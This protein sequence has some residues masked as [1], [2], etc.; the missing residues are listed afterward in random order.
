MLG[1]VRKCLRNASFWRLALLFLTMPV[2]QAQQ[3]IHVPADRPTIQAGIDAAQNGDTVLVSPGTYNEN[4]DFRG[5]GIV[6]TSGAASYAEAAA[7]VINAAVNGPVVKLMASEPATAV[8]NGFTIQGGYGLENGTDI[9]A[10]VA[11]YGS[12]PAITN[13]VIQKNIGC[14]IVV[15]RGGSPI[16]QGND[17]RQNRTIEPTQL[18][19]APTCGGAMSQPNDGAGVAMVHAGSVTL[20]GNI[21]E[22]NSTLNSGGTTPGGSGDGGTIDG[23][24][25]YIAFTQKAF[26][27]NN[28][29]RNNAGVSQA[30]IDAPTG[31]P[32]GQ[33]ILIQNFFYV[34]Q[35][36]PPH[37]NAF[38]D[39]SSGTVPTQLIAINNTFSF[40]LE[41]DQN[42]TADSVI[43]NNIIGALNC[44]YVP[45]PP[46]ISHNDIYGPSLYPSFVCPLGPGNIS[47]DPQFLNPTQGNFHTQR[48]SPVV[49]AGDINAPQIPPTDLDGKNRTVCGTIDMGVY[50]VHPQPATVV[51]SSL[52]PSVGG[53]AV[54]FGA[55][56]PG[57]CN[58]PTGTVT[59]FDG[60][61]AL[62]S[63]PL[64]SGATAS[65]TTASLTVGTHT[66]TV[67]YSGDFNFDPSTSTP[68]TQVVTGYPTTTTLAA[69]PDP[70]NAFGSLTLTSTV[71]S[72]F[73]TPSGTITF[74][75]GGT[76]LAT[77]PLNANGQAS[78]TI[79]TLGAGTYNL[80]AIYAATTTY[81][82]SSSAPVTETVLGAESTTSLKASPNPAPVGQTVT[83]AAIVKAAQGSAV[84][85]GTVTF[86]DGQTVLG[87]APVSTV[88]SASF[89][90]S[91]LAAGTHTITASYGGDANFSRSSA[92]V[93][94]TITVLAT[95]LS[96]SASP[97][98]AGSGQ[99]VTLTATLVSAAAGI[100]LIGTITFEDGGNPIGTGTLDATGSATLTTSTLAVGTHSL[101]AVFSGSGNLGG[102]TSAAVAETI[103]ASAFSLSLTPATLVLHDG[104]TG[105]TA[106]GLGSTGAY[107]GTLS[108]SLGG[109]PTHATGVFGAP[110][111][112]LQ[113]NGQTTTSLTISTQIL[114]ATAAVHAPV[115][116]GGRVLAVSFAGLLLAPFSLLRRRRRRASGLLTLFA[117]TVLLG[118]NGCTS[119]GYAIQ[120][121]QPG[122][123]TVPVIATDAHGITKTV[124]LALTIAA[125]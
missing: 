78:A 1:K 106:V 76:M 34:D 81:A 8:L 100:P 75:A 69:L 49:A 5:K 16:I 53:T 112:L 57:N 113:A 91:S 44:N 41:I 51:T 23:A 108:L 28:I 25:V 15:S 67:G 17:I 11:V 7:T 13:N 74:S 80:V 82:G 62:G 32:N 120:T 102:S 70:V 89:S 12:F 20:E 96:L 122:T 99:P 104:Q 92:S 22:Q 14:G 86:S 21:I 55:T 59:F 84:P 36:A 37:A 64:S 79:S 33:I 88:G 39:V 60:A 114:P 35:S 119:S 61:N 66:I 9:A 111:V 43:A 97:N 40:D 94:E 2:L 29:V 103:I 90:T 42:Y 117:V 52:S 72:N 38:V 83:F 18:T 121:V 95:T 123:Y 85:T 4:I 109:L 116:K 118:I 54:T 45:Q 26:L 31:E 68:L 50:E 71:A 30:G 98:P 63:E 125:E 124:N 107:A 27:K 93:T 3:T 56:V 6:V 10:G 110:S 58:V 101:T 65:L 87:T 47:A 46:L 48:T 73:G 24:G 105:V 77:V 19:L 115:W